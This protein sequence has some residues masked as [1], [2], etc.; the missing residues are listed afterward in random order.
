MTRT[1]KK[2]LTVLSIL[3][4]IYS[5]IIF[6]TYTIIPLE[7]LIPPTQTIPEVALSIP[8]W[9]FGLIT[10]GIMLVIYG[11]FSLAGY[12]FAR[13]LEI[14][15]LYRENVG[16]RKL[17]LWPML[18]GLAAGII[19]IIIDRILALTGLS[20]GFPHPGFPL[21]LISSATAGIGEEILFRGLVMGLWAFLANLFLRRYNRTQLAL[22]IGNIIAAFAFSAGH[23]PSAMILYGTTNLAEIPVPIFVEGLMINSFVGLVA[24]ER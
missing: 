9:Q 4:V 5:I 18:L 1:S 13:K 2:Q 19:V 22:W 16:W 10:A 6:A 21:S 8:H 15:P 3:L 20:K 17:F 23:L 14:P 24:G 12:W 11:L 7:K